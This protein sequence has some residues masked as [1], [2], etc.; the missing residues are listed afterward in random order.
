MAVSG[1]TVLL[2]NCSPILIAGAGYPA[3][4]QAQWSDYNYGGG[5]AGGAGYYPTPQGSNP[6]SSYN[7]GAYA[8]TGSYN[9][10]RTDSTGAYASAVPQAQGYN[11]S[12]SQ[13]PQQALYG[14]GQQ[15]G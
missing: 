9:S 3:A 12:Q 13:Q 2:Y 4:Y 8:S 15:Q 7:G 14:Y 6:A 1:P 5:S 10:S 11:Y